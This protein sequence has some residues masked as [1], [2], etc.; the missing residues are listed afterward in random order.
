[1]SQLT[2]FNQLQAD[3]TTFVAPVK[4]LVVTDKAS[5]EAAGSTLREVKH[6]ER[7]VEEM[8]KKLVGPLNDEV[9]RI[10]DYARLVSAPLGDAEGHLKKQLL[11]FERLLEAEREAERR[12][13]LE[14]RVK[15]EAEAREKIRLETEKAKTLAMFE[16]D[17]AAAEIEA[18]AAAEA[19]RIEFEAK[20]A[21]WDASKEIS[22]NKV[23][24]V[25]RVWRSEVVDPDLVPSQYLS[26]DEKKIKAA[27]ASGIREIPGVRIFQDAIMA[28]R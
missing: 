2:A 24:G 8:R 11:A 13:E 16:T 10:N 20:K 18:K 22:A 9:K 3:L 17:E 25:R 6:W 27:V 12:K 21:G 14:E 15:R 1:M 19:Q 23:S 4:A 26:V 5:C 7:K 28:V